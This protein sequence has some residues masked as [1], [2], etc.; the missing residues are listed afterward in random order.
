[1]L[2]NEHEAFLHHVQII[3]IHLKIYFFLETGKIILREQWHLP[4]LWFSKKTMTFIV[5]MTMQSTKEFQ[6]EQKI[7]LKWS[8]TTKIYWWPIGLY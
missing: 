5:M 1:M 7:A 4:L 6:L 3:T 8:K 2:D